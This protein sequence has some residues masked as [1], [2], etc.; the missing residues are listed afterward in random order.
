MADEAIKILSHNRVLKNA[1]VGSHK[2]T[3][4]PSECQILFYLPTWE[5]RL[6]ALLALGESTCWVVSATI[7]VLDLILVIRLD[8]V[9]LSSVSN[10]VSETMLVFDLIL[11]LRLDG[12]TTFSSDSASR[13]VDFLVRFGFSISVAESCFL[14][15]RTFNIKK[16][17]YQKTR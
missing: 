7:L 15:S 16:V 3:Q 10:G 13:T 11:V 4:R 17:K 6:A 14:L 8:G 9:P 5:I 12:V 2:V 1:L